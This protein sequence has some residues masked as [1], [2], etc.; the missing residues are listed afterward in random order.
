MRDM[1]HR[2]RQQRHQP[3]HQRRLLQLTMGHQRADMQ[4]RAVLPDVAQPGQRAD[5]DQAAGRGQPQIEHRH[6][7]LAASQNLRGFAA[8]R[9]LLEGLRQRRHADVFEIGC[10]HAQALLQ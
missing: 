6:Q 10:L 8:L 3:G 9:Q 7:A 4:R 1:R 5:V 2:L